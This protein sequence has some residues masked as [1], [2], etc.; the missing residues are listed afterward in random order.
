MASGFERAH[1]GHRS[2][3][4]TLPFNTQGLPSI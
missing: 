2:S 3:R 1:V 4:S